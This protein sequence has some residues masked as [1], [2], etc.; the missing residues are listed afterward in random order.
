MDAGACVDCNVIDCNLLFERKKAPEA[1]KETSYEKP[2]LRLSYLEL[3][4]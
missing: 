2:P 3:S 1:R 4:R